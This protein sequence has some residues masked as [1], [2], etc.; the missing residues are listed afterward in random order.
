MT[1]NK[2]K[3]PQQPNQMPKTYQWI[4]LTWFILSAIVTFFVFTGGATIALTQHTEPNE[5]VAETI[6]LVLGITAYLT[7][8]CVGVYGTYNYYQRI[9][10]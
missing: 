9:N 2:T 1:N 5:P 10:S 7:F 6:W 4:I 8:Y 3:Q